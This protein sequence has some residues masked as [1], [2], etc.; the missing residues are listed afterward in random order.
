MSAAAIPPAASTVRRLGPYLLKALLGKSERSMLWHVEDER[1]RQERLLLMPRKLPVDEA[2]WLSAARA[3]QRVTHPGLAP[4]VDV[5]LLDGHGFVAY[6]RALGLT[7]DERLSRHRLPPPADA[8]QW[9]A[10]A[11]QGL[12]ALHEAGHVLGDVQPYQWLIPGDGHAVL[13]G[14][15]LMGAVPGADAEARQVQRA[16]AAE[17][18][19]CLGLL[20]NRLLGGAAPLATTDPRA[21]LRRIPPHGQDFVRLGHSAAHP[22]PEPL[23]AICNRATAT[24]P[25]QRYPSA[26]AMARALE[27]WVDHDRHPQGG[28]VGQLL[29]K[30]QRFGGL[31]GTRPEAVKQVQA[32]GLERL[33]RGALADLVLQDL[34]LSFELLRRVNH[35]R[36]REGRAAFGTVLSVQRALALLGLKEVAQAASAL[37]PWPGVLAP[38]RLLNLRL[39]LAR[40]H[41]AADVAQALAP[42]GYEPEVV[43]LVTYTQSL[44]RLMLQYHLADESDQIERLM[45][46]PPPTDA[47][48]HPSGM[49]EPQA[50]FA[51]LGCDLGALTMATLRA[52]GLADGLHAMAT[53]PDPDSPIHTPNSDAETL[54][55][56]AAMATDLVDALA[57]PMPRRRQA[58]DAAVR[59][60]AR[61]LGL[62]LHDVHLALYPEAAQV[63]VD[64]TWA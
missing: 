53:R 21:V 7:L 15:G 27:A 48:P 42:A 34:A 56:C 24:Q 55:L 33:H 5:G 38:E 64:R 45:Q 29:D 41:K 51:V 16:E 26:R 49:S 4:V 57:L 35:T 23:R 31:P 62:K 11:A 61:P 46:P 39:A 28:T 63:A 30:L 59:R 47:Q 19:L 32:G 44:G 54:R 43:R 12:A 13:L 8:A 3:A 58:I 18:V 37:R 9:A 50:A 17:E 52:W 2:A 25:L 14:V 1:V 36:L 22:I 6:E 60:F 20:L 40:A 10:Q